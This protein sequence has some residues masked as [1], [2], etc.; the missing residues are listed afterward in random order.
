MSKALDILS[1]EVVKSIRE[2]SKDFTFDK[3][4]QGHVMKV[5]PDNRYEVEMNR[6]RYSTYSINDTSYRVGETVW[7]TAPQNNYSSMF[8]IGRKKD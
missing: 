2:E 6:T 8:I 4:Y 7:L 3:T 1:K 5:L